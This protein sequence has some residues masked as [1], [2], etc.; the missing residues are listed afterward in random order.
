MSDL[1]NQNTGGLML[2]KGDVSLKANGPTADIIVYAVLAGTVLFG[3]AEIVRAFR[4]RPATNN[5]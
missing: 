3:A 5:A 2:S 1:T 4:R